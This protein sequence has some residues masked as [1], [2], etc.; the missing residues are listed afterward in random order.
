MREAKQDG[1]RRR[2]LLAG[3]VAAAAA[4]AGTARAQGA[5]GEEGPARPLRLIVPFPAGGAADI[6]TRTLAEALRP[7]LGHAVLVENLPGANGNLGAAAFAR[8]EPD[9]ATLLSSPPGP[10]AINQSLY[11]GLAFDPTQFVPITVLAKVP[12]VVVVNP[13]LG[14]SDVPGLI[15]AARARPGAMTYASQGS[16]STSHLTAAMFEMLAGLRL[17]HVPYRGEAPALVDVMAGQV[18]M[19]FGNIAAALPQHQAGRLRILAV[20][21]RARA[22]VL[23]EVPA[24]PEVGLPGLISSAWFALAAPPGTPPA[25]AERLNALM[26]EALRA[27]ALRARY[28]ELGAE[29]VGEGTAATAAFFREEAERWAAVIRTARVTVD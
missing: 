2:A 20:T 1:V 7:R 15:E 29:A 23:P 18:N 22:A 24:T 8:A 25:L 9:G 28:R 6:L 16:G 17:V 5:A 13:G 3:A 27:P 26:A 4:A 11:R 12:N 10:L 19:M 14:I 21:D